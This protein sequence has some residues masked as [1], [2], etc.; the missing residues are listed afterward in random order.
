MNEKGDPGEG[1]ELINDVLK[2]FKAAA[3]KKGNK[4]SLMIDGDL[5][6]LAD[7]RDESIWF[8]GELLPPDGASFILTF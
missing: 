5:R 4:G 6:A 1:G 2:N 7:E 8:P 3:E